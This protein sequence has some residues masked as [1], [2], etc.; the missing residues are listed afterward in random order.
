M[1]KCVVGILRECLAMPTFTKKQEALV[2]IMLRIRDDEESI[3]QLVVDTF[4]EQ[5]F[6]GASADN[7]ARAQQL[8]T[9]VYTVYSNLKSHGQVS[10]G[11]TQEAWLG[12]GRGLGFQF[13]V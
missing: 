10:C 7:D 12:R 1:R 5:W 8:V 9:V 4:Q 3:Q 11:A 13:R 6:S 2:R